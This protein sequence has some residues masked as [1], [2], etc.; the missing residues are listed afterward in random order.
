M[1]II[2]GLSFGVLFMLICGLLG[3][4]IGYEVLHI[5]F[6]LAFVFGLGGFAL[7]A[8]MGA[9]LGRVPRLLDKI[10]ALEARLAQMQADIR[11]MRSEQA[12]QKEKASARAAQPEP[13]EDVRPEPSPGLEAQRPTPQFE[14]PKAIVKPADKPAAAKQATMEKQ[15]AKETPRPAPPPVPPRPQA[16]AVATQEPPAGRP[17]NP[18]EQGVNKAAEFIRN[19]FTTGNVVAR[20]GIIV[21]FFGVAFLLKYATTRYHVAIEY[22]FMTVAVLAMAMTILGFRLR[23]RRRGFA[24]LLQGGG[25]GILYMTVFFAAKLYHLMPLGMAFG[26]MVVLVGLMGAVAVF[27]DARAT[28]FIGM[29]GGFLAPVLTSSGAGQHV[30]LFSY[31]AVLGLGIL[32]VAWY[33]S[34]RELNLLGFMFTFGV[35]GL[36]GANH[37]KPELFA[38]TEP[39]LII[40]F[41][42]YES[43]AVLFALRQPVHLRGFVDGTLV[44][45]TP[46]VAFAFQS[47]LVKHIPYG[48]AYTALGASIF[49]LILT[50]ALWKRQIPGLQV[51]TESFLALCVVFVSLAIPLGLSGKWTSAIY[52]FEG[53]GLIWIGIRQNRVFARFFGFL[54]QLAGAIFLVENLGHSRHLTPVVNS[55]CLGFAFVALGGLFSSYFYYKH[56]DAAGEMEK[57]LH[58]VLLAWGV[59]WWLAGGLREVELHIPHTMD[60]W[61]AA[62][63]TANMALLFITATALAMHAL[64]KKLDWKAMGYAL[65]GFAPALTLFYWLG[66]DKGFYHDNPLAKLGWAAWPCALAVLYF[67]L[68]QHEGEAPEKASKI[69]HALG[70]WLVILLL[71]SQASWGLDELVNG[72]KVWPMVAWGLIPGL[73][74]GLLLF[75]G[76]SLGWPVSWN[77]SFYR[78]GVLWPILA[79][80][81]LWCIAAIVHPGDPTP[82]PYIPVVNPLELTQA[83]V[84]TI[85]CVAAAGFKQSPWKTVDDH[86]FKI[87]CFGFLGLLIFI[88]SNAVLCRSV[89]NFADIRFNRLW[90]SM[91]FQ[92]ALSLFWTLWA[93]AL[94]GA[95][96]KKGW[97]IVWFAGAGL[98][99]VVTLKLITVD[100]SHSGALWRV[101][102]FIGSG[103]LMVVI[104]Y[105]AP[106]PP[107]QIKDDNL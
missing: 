19:F 65:V 103:I 64:I 1:A 51:L 32:G 94:T 105:T 52:A 63:Y 97:R 101:A 27:Q 75:Q 102:S 37:Y 93:V 73:F 74:A 77:R 42:F 33:K 66:L 13:Q 55:D 4:A 7:G 84:L 53:A 98:I 96:S 29:V 106:L 104:G 91:L 30:I 71:A 60:Y 83:F 45:G 10:S 23:E 62:S 14:A 48:L 61:E 5:G 46:I 3:A 9:I 56:K 26:L 54:L 72:A 15:H 89:V 28:A 100:L 36:W 2:F 40:F 95:A 34:W 78:G 6:S 81:L 44:F 47:V 11:A 87:L 59:L 82:L 35:A 17:I 31:Y 88:V 80:C 41:V 49:Y 39:F 24:L 22:R 8:Y 92:M 79:F 99:G 50:K 12:K 70:C 58:L 67:I 25:I 86:G 69:W 43:I 85:L 107:Q 57:P 76:N 38:S 16:R 68:K 20:I 18:I 21:L 90:D